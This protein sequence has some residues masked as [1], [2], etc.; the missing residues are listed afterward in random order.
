MTERELQ[1]AVIAVGRLLGWRTA[2]FRTALSQSGKWH[3]PVGGDGKGWPDLVLCRD[4][5]VFAELKAQRGT[6]SDE[7]KD[8]LAA[9]S[10]AGA[11]VYVWRPADWLDG[12]IEAVLRRRS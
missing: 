1:G 9:L 8:W 5:I 3:T 7:Q 4:R 12:T 2:H 10:N 11:E 6:T